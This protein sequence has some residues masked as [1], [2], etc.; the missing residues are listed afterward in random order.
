MLIQRLE[1]GKEGAGL[2]ATVAGQVFAFG[3]GA[4]LHLL[5]DAVRQ[6]WNELL[7]AVDRTAGDRLRV[8]EKRLFGVFACLFDVVGAT[9][10]GTSLPNR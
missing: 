6:R 3:A 1:R 10:A 9:G 8:L 2:R 5:D 4:V 7:H